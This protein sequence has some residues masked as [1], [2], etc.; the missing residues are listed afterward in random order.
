MWRS[1]VVTFGRTWTSC[2]IYMEYKTE[3]DVTTP[4]YSTHM[5]RM[6]RSRVSLHLFE[7]QGVVSYIQSVRPN[8]T[9]WL[10]H[11][12]FSHLTTCRTRRSH[13]VYTEFE[14][15]FDDMTLSH[16]SFT[17]LLLF[18]L[19]VKK[20]CRQIQSDFKKMCRIYGIWDRIWRHDTFTFDT[21]RRIRRSHVVTFG[22]TWRSFVVYTEFETEFHD[23][24]PSYSTVCVGCEGVVS[25]NSVRFQEDLSY[26]RSLRLNS[27][28]RLLHIWPNVSDAKESCRHVRSNVKE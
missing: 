2:V 5:C 17:W 25:S 15:E 21:M 9:T 27:T 19:H 28:T 20:S 6:C 14:T 23:M 16:D 13:V 12:T 11:M 24:N 7:C 8:L 26:I 10:L 18:R 22:R 4:W 3:F 1:R